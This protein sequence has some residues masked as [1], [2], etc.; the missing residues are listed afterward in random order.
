M[1]ISSMH[2]MDDFNTDFRWN[3]QFQKEIDELR[4]QLQEAGDSD[5]DAVVD[6]A[7]KPSKKLRTEEEQAAIRVRRERTTKV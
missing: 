4:R 1:A 3:A 2:L 6:D 5:D 7:K